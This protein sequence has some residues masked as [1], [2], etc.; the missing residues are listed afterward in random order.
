MLQ[1]SQGFALD[2]PTVHR[3]GRSLIE[4]ESFLARLVVDISGKIYG[5][6]E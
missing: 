3:D 5:F 4:S 1:P 2:N 6:A